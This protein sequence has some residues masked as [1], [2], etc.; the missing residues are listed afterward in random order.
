M[1]LSSLISVQ[2]TQTWR[3]KLTRST[4]LWSA[5]VQLRWS[6]FY[7]VLLCNF[8]CSRFYG[9]LL[10]NFRCARFYGVLLCNFRCARFYGVLLCNFRCTICYTCWHDDAAT[11]ILSQRNNRVTRDH[12]L[13]LCLSRDRDFWPRF[14]NLLYYYWIFTTVMMWPRF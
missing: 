4:I 6:R 7:G 8:R 3:R 11:T 1:V 2:G 5:T 13:L 9:V 12:G 10:C 14:L